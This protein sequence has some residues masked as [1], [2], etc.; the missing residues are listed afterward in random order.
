MPLLSV[1]FG[2]FPAPSV[3]VFS[4]LLFRFS[5][6]VSFVFL[7]FFHLI[8]IMILFGFLF[9]FVFLGG[10]KPISS[11][12]FPPPIPV[13]PGPLLPQSVSSLVL[14]RVYVLFGFS[15]LG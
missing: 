2:E 6:L 10:K 15:S 8:I 4:R 14:S 9:C 5:P 11:F 1:W 12:F 3:G 13:H 7:S